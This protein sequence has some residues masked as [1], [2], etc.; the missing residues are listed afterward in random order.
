M[1]IRVHRVPFN[2][3]AH[4]KEDEESLKESKDYELPKGISTKKLL[5]HTIFILFRILK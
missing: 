2:R 5:L 1:P 3:I 4:N